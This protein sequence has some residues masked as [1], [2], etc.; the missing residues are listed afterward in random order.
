MLIGIRTNRPEYRN[1][2]AEEIR[3]FTGLAEIVFLEAGE[4]ADLVFDIEMTSGPDGLYTIT[5]S[6]GAA[7]DE[8]TFTV[9]ETGRLA[10]KK[11]EKRNIKLAAYR[12][13]QQLYPDVEPMQEIQ[14]ICR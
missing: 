9:P 2:I 3:L 10:I 12:H 7:R 6:A 8:A 4:T 13:L 5:S 14:R 1:D 11:L